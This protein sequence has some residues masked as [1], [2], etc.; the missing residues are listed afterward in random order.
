MADPFEIWRLAW[1]NA[2]ARGFQ[3][4]ADLIPAQAPSREAAPIAVAP[5]PVFFGRVRLELSTMRL[6]EQREPTATQAP[7][8]V[9]RRSFRGS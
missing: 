8:D 6:I 2:A 3:Q 9:D 5:S 7:A 1:A 4:L